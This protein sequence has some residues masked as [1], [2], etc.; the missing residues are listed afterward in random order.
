MK[1]EIRLPADFK[2][3]QGDVVVSN[4]DDSINP[5]IEAAIKN[6]PLFSRYAAYHFNGIIWWNDKLG[7]WCG[8]VWV[9]RQYVAFYL[10]EN[11]SLLADEMNFHHGKGE[12]P[13]LSNIPG[14]F[15]KR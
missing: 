13:N 6:K 14:Y 12:G 2:E 1:C 5:E 9:L 11:L 10:A 3:Y 8:E 15:D 7:Y 4:L